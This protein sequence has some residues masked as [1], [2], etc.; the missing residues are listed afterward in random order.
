MTDDQII[1]DVL[2]NLNQWDKDNRDT[3]MEI[4]FFIKSKFKLGERKCFELTIKMVKAGLVYRFRHNDYLIT[5][6]GRK[7]GDKP[8]GWLGQPKSIQPGFDFLRALNS[9]T[10][11]I[12]SSPRK[13]DKLQQYIKIL[14][15]YM[16][17]WWWAYLI[18][19]FVGY[20]QLYMEYSWFIPK[21]NQDSHLTDTLY[22]GTALKDTTVQRKNIQKPFPTGKLI[23]LDSSLSD[24]KINL[25]QKNQSQQDTLHRVRDQLRQR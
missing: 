21:Q 1:H 17:K 13:N 4:P 25:K 11:I 18:P 2:D 14:K 7:I 19:I 20:V 8:D 10:T 3:T 23:Q 22:R 24:D 12:K 16:I 6:K 15:E 9:T 5:D